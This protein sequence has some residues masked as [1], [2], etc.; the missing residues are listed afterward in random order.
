M[1]IKKILIS[2]IFSLLLSQDISGNY[3]LSGLSAVYYD[4]VRYDVS[5]YIEDNYGFGISAVG[6]S[7]RKA[8]QYA[9]NISTLILSLF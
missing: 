2:S 1:T 6:D 4:F 7:Y 8:K 3:K 5:L 9:L